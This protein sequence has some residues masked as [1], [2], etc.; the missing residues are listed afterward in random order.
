MNLTGSATDVSADDTAAG[1]S[2][3][4]TVTR[5]GSTY[6]TGSAANFSFVPGNQGTYNV[7]LVA[8]DKD[9]SASA[10]ATPATLC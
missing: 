3:A 5:D 7:T 2:Y 4:W 6:A 8:T 1:F 9:G 10:P